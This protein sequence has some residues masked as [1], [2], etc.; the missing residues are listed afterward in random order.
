MLITPKVDETQE[1]IEIA[2]DF[3]NPLDL[4]REAISNSYDAKATE[5]R[6]SFAVIK[7][8][9][10]ATLLIKLID[11]GTGMTLDQLQSFFDL[12][13]ST[14]RG[15]KQTIGEK[16]HG[17]K[18][19][20]NSRRIEVRTSTGI[21]AHLAI[22]DDPFRRLHDRKIPTVEVTALDVSSQGK[23]TEITMHGYN[24][25]RR[26]KFTHPILKDYVTWFT[27]H[28]AIDTVFVAD[29]PKTTLLLRGLGRD[30]DEEIPQG[31]P[32]PSDSKDI[33]HL[34]EEYLVKAPDY[35][36]KRIL[37]TGCLK[38]F[39]EVAY[40]ALKKGGPGWTR[41]SDQRIMSPLL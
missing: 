21:E 37:R 8:F 22:M 34:F 41:T 39:P 2:N 29:E 18:V 35:Y 23:G 36:A 38:N 24:N 19:Y 33:N 5:I 3:S 13:N 26:D 9:G 31:H 40:Q 6:I 1:F 25:N 7:E 28:G 12:G 27:K 20:F 32:F 11:N 17:T 30:L 14:R 10:E 15:D 16:G 4:V